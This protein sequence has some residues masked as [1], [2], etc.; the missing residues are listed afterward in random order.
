MAAQEGDNIIVIRDGNGGMTAGNLA[1]VLS[2]HQ[3]QGVLVQRHSQT[4][5]ATVTNSETRNPID[6]LWCTRR[7][8]IR[9]GG[10]LPFEA[11]TPKTN[12]RTL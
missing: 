4:T 8:P 10:Y 7:L 6:G 12:H 2:E 3:L 9:C 1:Q 11:L 5:K